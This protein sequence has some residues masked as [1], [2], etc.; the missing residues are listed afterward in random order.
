MEDG[1]GLTN[2]SGREGH[3]EKRQLD[4]QRRMEDLRAALVNGMEFIMAEF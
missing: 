3:S 1:K 2:L 4:V